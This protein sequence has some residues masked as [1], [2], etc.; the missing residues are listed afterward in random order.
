MIEGRVYVLRQAGFDLYRGT[1][2]EKAMKMWTE[3]VEEVR[4]RIKPPDLIPAGARQLNAS[5]YYSIVVCLDM[6][7]Q[8]GERNYWLERWEKE[9]PD[10]QQ[11]AVQKEFLQRKRGTLQVTGPLRAVTF[12]EA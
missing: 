3:A 12:P 11:V 4:R 2:Y 7:N 6:L 9:H 1:H 10:D 5:M 8:L